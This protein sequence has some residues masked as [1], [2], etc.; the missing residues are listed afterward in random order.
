MLTFLSSNKHKLHLAENNLSPLG[1]TFKQD[2]FPF[3][4]IQSDNPTE[5]TID[6]AQQAFKILQKPFFVTDDS[7]YI[8][9][10]NGFPGAYMKHIN[11]K[12]KENDFLRLMQPYA[13]REIILHRVLC[14]I[15]QDGPRI[16]EDR[17]VGEVLKEATNYGE[18]PLLNIISFLPSNKSVAQ[19]WD[20]GTQQLP[21]ETM[22]IDFA[23]WYS[24]NR[25]II[26]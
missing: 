15:D 1:V 4:E 21:H 11:G 2:V 8:T 25:K 18:I 20:E 5:I 19:A 13:N 17:L 7:W 24:L 14:Y 16:F 3:I 26:I 12:L 6:K 22:W 9:A 10:L 23:Q